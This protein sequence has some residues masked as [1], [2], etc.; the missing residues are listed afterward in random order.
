MKREEA[1]IRGE[2]EREELCIGTKLG[3]FSQATVNLLD[4]PVAAV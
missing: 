4:S 2:R 1:G 3:N